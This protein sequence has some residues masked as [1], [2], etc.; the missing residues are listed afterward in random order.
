MFFFLIK[1]VK[2]YIGLILIRK[3]LDGV[4]RFSNVLML[5]FYRVRKYFIFVFEC[6]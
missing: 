5:G 2:Y 6:Y 3:D 4:I 1:K